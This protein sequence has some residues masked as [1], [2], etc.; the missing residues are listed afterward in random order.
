MNLRKYDPLQ[1]Y[2]FFKTSS[3]FPVIP[4][5]Q[6]S[7][8][9]YYLNFNLFNLLAGSPA[10]VK[11]MISPWR[12]H[13]C[14]LPRG[15]EAYAVL[16]RTGPCSVLTVDSHKDIGHHGPFSPCGP[17]IHNQVQGPTAP[18]MTILI[19]VPCDVVS[20]PHKSGC[21]GFY[22]GWFAKR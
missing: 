18:N 14:A 11:M 4:E 1:N 22:L 3:S 6:T 20:P 13:R 5:V 7:F 8:F 2:Q 10:A 19:N 12:L 16:T 9:C 17:W 21:L 15:S